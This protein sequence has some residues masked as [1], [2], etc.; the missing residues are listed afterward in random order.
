[1]ISQRAD[2]TKKEIPRTALH[3]V[4]ITVREANEALQNLG[5]HIGILL[6][7]AEVANAD[8]HILK[9]DSGMPVRRN[10]WTAC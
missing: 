1:M 5:D 6:E 10:F 2:Q 7:E 9:L 4:V 3:P 8:L